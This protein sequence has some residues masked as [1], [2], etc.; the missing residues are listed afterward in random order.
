[1]AASLASSVAQNVY[2]L[3][4]VGYVNVTLPAGQFTCIANP[5]DAS[6][7]GTIAGGNDITNLFPASAGIPGSSTIATWNSSL[8]DYDAPHTFLSRSSAWDSNLTMNPGL[9]ALFYNNGGSDLVI[10]FVGQVQQG[11][12]TVATLPPGAFTMAGSPVPL[13]GGVTNLNTTLGLVPSASDTVAT[14]NGTLNDWNAP[15]TW[16]SRSGNWDNP[17]YAIN[18]GQGFLYYNNGSANTWASNFTVQ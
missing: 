16:L 6:V 14:W 18:P 4:V 7:G 8:N 9:G 5:L 3:N 17:A 11:A 13:G 2:S 12:Y 15:A 1:M 10:T